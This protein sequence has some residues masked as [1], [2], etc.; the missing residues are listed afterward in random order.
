MN[1]ELINETIGLMDFDLIEAADEAPQSA[2]AARVTPFVKRPWLKWAAAAVAIVVIAA[3]T[4]LALK[5]I[6]SFRNENFVA[7]NGSGNSGVV[8]PVDSSESESSEPDSSSAP[9]LDNTD[10]VSN[11]S[12]VP[13]VNS[14]PS[15]SGSEG[16]SSETHTGEQG[17]ET[18]ETPNQPEKPDK[19]NDPYYPFD[20]DDIYGTPYLKWEEPSGETGEFIKTNMPAVT[21]LINGKAL[22][23]SY[24]KSVY[25][26]KTADRDLDGNEGIY[27]IDYYKD[28]R[29]GTLAKN[30]NSGRLMQ[31]DTSIPYQEPGE[32]YVI[33]TNRDAIDKAKQV[34]IS[35]DVALSGIENAA[36][37]VYPS[38]DN[39]VIRLSVHEGNVEVYIDKNGG[40]LKL[41]VNEEFTDQLSS[42]RLSAASEKVY[43]KIAELKSNNP[44]WKYAV[45]R[46]HY[47][48]WGDVI[49]AVFDVVGFM[50]GNESEYTTRQY[51][52][53]V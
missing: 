15:Q 12:D 24:Q 23:F 14:D 38:G 16:V 18:P 42:A 33:S 47:E 4:P 49:Y 10:I 45:L 34:A 44:N 43:T 52:C 46:T 8:V 51:H 39:Y 29:G 6:G 9:E 13:V 17:S 3:G 2:G 48:K 7:P 41:I 5:A 31:Y 35:T 1:Y 36:A 32:V 40:L 37:S 53:V 25:I 28:G 27:I 26:K 19:P 22:T 11:S 21:Y 20:P 50:D 30:E